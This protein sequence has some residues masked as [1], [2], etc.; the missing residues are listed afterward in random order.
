MP[1]ISKVAPLSAEDIWK[2]KKP[3]TSNT[4]FLDGEIYAMAGVNDAHAT[5]A[6]NLF[7]LLHSHLQGGPC[8]FYISDGPR[9]TSQCLFFPDV[10]I[11]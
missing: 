11:T 5:L 7:A 3:P 6:G 10:V 8:R 2:A 9:G 1:I 4:K